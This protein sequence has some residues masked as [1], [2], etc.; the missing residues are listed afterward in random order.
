MDPFGNSSSQ[1]QSLQVDR[2]VRPE[3]VTKRPP[4][5]KNKDSIKV[6]DEK[7]ESSLRDLVESMKIQDGQK[8]P[9]SQNQDDFKGDNEPVKAYMDS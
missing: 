4:I 8:P 2:P 1:F 6:T 9:S 7:E 5:A 3:G